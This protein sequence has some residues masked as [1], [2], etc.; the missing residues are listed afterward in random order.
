MGPSTSSQACVSS[1]AEANTAA[2]AIHPVWCKPP[3]MV[4][5]SGLPGLEA[6]S[7]DAAFSPEVEGAV[8][9]L[10]TGATEESP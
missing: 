7:L 4:R 3:S 8:A 6:T 9:A 1:G 2:P 10:I 5:R